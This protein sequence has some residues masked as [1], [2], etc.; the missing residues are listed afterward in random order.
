M[1]ISD[2]FLLMKTINTF[3]LFRYGQG[4]KSITR[5]INK[6][7][8]TLKTFYIL[9]HNLIKVIK[10]CPYRLCKTYIAQVGFI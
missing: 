2:I 8:M 3:N 4:I 9:F 5:N 7:K 1:F 10:A 6:S